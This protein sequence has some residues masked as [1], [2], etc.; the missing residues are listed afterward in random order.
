MDGFEK[1]R[2]NTAIVA[3]TFSDSSSSKP[4]GISVKT[5]NPRRAWVCSLLRLDVLRKDRGRASSV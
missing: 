1:R 3:D 5:Q 4:G 2:T